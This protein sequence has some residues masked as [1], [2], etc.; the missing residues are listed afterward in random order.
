[1]LKRFTGP[2]MFRLF[3]ALAV[4]FHHIS[5]LAIGTAAVYVFF[6]LSGYWIFKMYSGRYSATKQRYFTYLASRA[7]RLLPVFLLINLGMLSF[8]LFRG[9]LPHYWPATSRA[10]FILSNFLILGYSSLHFQPIV[11]AWSLDVEVEF[12]LVAPI[13]ILLLARLKFPVIWILIAGSISL[14]SALLHSPV[15]LLNFIVFF[16]VGMVAASAN[17][18]PQEGLELRP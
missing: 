3:L 12:Y 11:P 18:K 17:W 14:V 2:G 8:M 1:L 15:P 7:W 9:T 4:F 13:L 6:G 10:H 5:S 16:I